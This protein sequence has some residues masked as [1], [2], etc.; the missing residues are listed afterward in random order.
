MIKW[1][2]LLS[3]CWKCLGSVNTSGQIESKPRVGSARVKNSG[4]VS[5]GRVTNSWPDDTSGKE[6]YDF[7]VGISKSCS[8][9]IYFIKIEILTAQLIFCENSMHVAENR[10]FLLH[11]RWHFEKLISLQISKQPKKLSKN[12]MTLLFFSVKAEIPY[13]S[14][15]EKGGHLRS[16]FCSKNSIFPKISCLSHFIQTNIASQVAP[17]FNFWKVWNL[18]FHWKKN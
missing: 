13:F 18:S 4:W 17:L 7:T 12:R 2:R 10:D 1:W 9:S 6:A 15:I 14:K 8:M 11:A 3:I 16:Y 5:S